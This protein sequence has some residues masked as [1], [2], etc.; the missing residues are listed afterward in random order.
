MSVHGL[1]IKKEAGTTSSA[2]LFVLHLQIKI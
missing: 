2:S 1:E